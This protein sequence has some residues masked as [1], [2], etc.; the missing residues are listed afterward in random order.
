MRRYLDIGYRHL[1]CGF[2]APFDAE[3]MERMQTEVRPM[4]EAA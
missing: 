4:L 3:T 1:I 2:P